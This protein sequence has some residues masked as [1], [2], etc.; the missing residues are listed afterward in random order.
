[1]DAKDG[2]GGWGHSRRDGDQKDR[3]AC[4][5]CGLDAGGLNQSCV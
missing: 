2:A 5:S 1:M 4:E 3:T